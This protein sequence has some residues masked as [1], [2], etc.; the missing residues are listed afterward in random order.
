M[1]H[2]QESYGI[3]AQFARHANVLFAHVGF[4]A[5]GSH[6][7][8]VHAQFVRHLQMVHGTNAGQQQSRH[9][10]LFHQWDD[11]AEV[12]LIGVS[13]EAV[14]HRAATQAIA[15]GDFDQRHTGGVQATGDRLHLLQRHLVAL[16]VHAVPQ[17][18]VMDGDF[19]ALQCHGAGSYQAATGTVGCRVNVPA[20]IS[21]AN[22]SAV[23]AAEA[24]MM[25]R[26]PAY[27]GR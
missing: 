23:R 21:S 11:G 19:L 14:V 7:Q 9:L 4:G 3:H 15:V 17:S 26:L 8:G 25:S 24:V 22:I 12:F 10:G 16:G 1:R 2:H 6:T 13:R 20:R 18:H 27:L 5:M